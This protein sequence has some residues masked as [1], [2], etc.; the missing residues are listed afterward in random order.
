MFRTILS[1]LLTALVVVQ[2]GCNAMRE[3]SRQMIDVFKPG[4]YEDWTENSTADPWIRQAGVEAR[5]HRERESVGEP[6]WF[7]NRLTSE[8]ARDIERNMGYDV[9]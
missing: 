8:K 7:H 2:A 3:N 9:H 6:D 5:G 1:G 4:D